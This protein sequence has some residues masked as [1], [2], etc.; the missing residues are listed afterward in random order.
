MRAAALALLVLAGCA[1]GSADEPA[2]PLAES[3]A[4]ERPAPEADAPRG[5]DAPD[6][7]ETVF[8]GAEVVFDTLEPEP[9]PPVE[10]PEP[11]PPPPRPQPA[12][13]PAPP[14]PPPGPP[15]A[16]SCDV[17]ETEGFC[18]A[19]TGTGWDLAEAE[20]GCAEAPSSTF[21]PEACPQ[22]G[23]IGTCVFTRD[24]GTDRRI[25]YTY[26]A[27]YD[28]DLARLACI[29]GEFTEE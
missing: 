15:V 24:D 14:P 7:A 17:R 27:P 20:G 25:V 3:D 1:R 11:A 6:E 26:Y 13:R 21:A 5:A 19:Y 18:F 22:E 28:L 23:R 4:P 8:D 2:A 29:G 9:R 16:G 10:I 12:P